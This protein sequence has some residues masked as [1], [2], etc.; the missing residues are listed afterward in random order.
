MEHDVVFKCRVTYRILPEGHVE[1]RM[2]ER[3]A[4]GVHECHVDT[5]C[6]RIF[7]WLVRCGGAVFCAVLL[8]D[9]SRCCAAKFFRAVCAVDFWGT[10]TV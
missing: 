1:M 4:C 9:G 7:L 5:F 3:G 8:V 2:V 10:A 6:P